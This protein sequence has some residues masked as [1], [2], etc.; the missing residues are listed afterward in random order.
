M[1]PQAVGATRLP[2]GELAV[3]ISSLAPVIVP[4][5]V[6]V[7][8]LFPVLVPLVIVPVPRKALSPLLLALGVCGST[9]RLV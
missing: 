7:S 8:F 4:I 3:S 6:S 1:T 2:S 5:P 9:D